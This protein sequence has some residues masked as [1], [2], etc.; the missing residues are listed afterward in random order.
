MF[1]QVRGHTVYSPALNKDSVILALGANH[2]E[3]AKQMSDLF[4][5]TY[6]LVEANPDLSNELAFDGRFSVLNYAVTDSEGPISFN[7]A[8]ND[9]GSSMLT[10]PKQNALNRVLRETVIV[11][12]KRLQSIISELGVSKIDLLKMDIEGAEVSVLASLEP[13]ILQR[14]G[15]ITVEFHSAPEFGFD[16]GLGVENVLR[17]MRKLDFITMDFSFHQ[18]I[19]VLLINKTI[20]KISSGDA[21]RWQYLRHPPL[22]VVRLYRSLP[23]GFRARVRELRG[24]ASK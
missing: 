15:Q 8:H 4:G 6:H 3:F 21:I 23:A 20:N 13:G 17:R 1:T 9:E 18:R 14:I 12:A 19:D 5:G 10:L 11:Q 16:L 22:W 2:G 24:K 7:L